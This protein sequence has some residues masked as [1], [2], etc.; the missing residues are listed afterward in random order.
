M[1]QRQLPCVGRPLDP[2]VPVTRSHV[3]GRQ[4][5]QIARRLRVSRFREFPELGDRLI[6]LPERDEHASQIEAREPEGGLTVG[7]VPVRVGCRVNLTLALENLA[8]VVVGLRVMRV[9]GNRLTIRV[10]GEV[11]FLLQTEQHAVIV[12]RRAQ[13]DAER[14]DRPVVLLGLRPV[15]R[16]AVQGDQI[17]VGF[18]ERRVLRERRFVRRDRALEIARFGELHTTPHLRHRIVSQRGD[19]REH[20]ILHGGPAR[21]V[22]RMAFERPLRFVTTAQRAQR[23]RERVVSRAPFGEQFDSALQVRDRFVVATLGRRDASE[24]ELRRRLRG[25]LMNERVEQ[26]PALVELAGFEQRFGQL[27]ARRQVIR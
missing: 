16:A 20:L 9:D 8:E 11:P 3:R 17:R 4:R 6:V 14:D 1:L 5:K 18:G 7:R 23:E 24:P 12:M 22:L 27:H 19:A 26:T 2:F 10:C 25:R 21:P 13:V 15:A